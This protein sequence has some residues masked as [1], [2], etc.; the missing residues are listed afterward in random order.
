MDNVTAPSMLPYVIIRPSGLPFR[1]EIEDLLLKNGFRVLLATPITC[2]SQLAE[3]FYF[4]KFGDA[5]TGKLQIGAQAWIKGTTLLFGDQ[6]LLCLLE[7]PSNTQGISHLLAVQEALVDLKRK[8]RSSKSHVKEV[9]SVSCLHEGEKYQ[10]FFDYLHCPDPDLS[11]I[12][13]EWNWMKD[14]GLLD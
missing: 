1:S 12:Q 10:V 13:N 11:Q 9:M 7:S 14:H 8:F 5:Q 3:Y 4:D 2:W 6:A